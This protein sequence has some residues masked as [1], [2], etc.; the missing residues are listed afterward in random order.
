MVN[1]KK[2]KMTSGITC[3]QLVKKL[4]LSREECIVKVNGKPA[5]DGRKIGAK[6]K[7]DVITIVFGG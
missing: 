1:G 7:V 4:S 2:R 5:A 6:D 3:A